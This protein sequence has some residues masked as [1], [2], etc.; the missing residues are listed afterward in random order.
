MYLFKTYSIQCEKSTQT[1]PHTFNKVRKSRYI[2]R[3]CFHMF[4]KDPQ[5]VPHKWNQEKKDGF[6]LSFISFFW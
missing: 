1:I 3:N 4:L 2:V 5:N 6:Q